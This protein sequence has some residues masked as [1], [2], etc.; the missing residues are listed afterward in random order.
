MCALLVSYM[1]RSIP[2]ALTKMQCEVDTES[3][4]YQDEERF[5]VSLDFAL[6]VAAVPLFPLGV[7]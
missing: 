6:E 7:K 4:H 2:A 5:P 3:C 1:E